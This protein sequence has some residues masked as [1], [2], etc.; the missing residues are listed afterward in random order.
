MKK[1]AEEKRRAQEREAELDKKRKKI[2]DEIMERYMRQNQ[3]SMMGKMMSGQ[4]LYGQGGIGSPVGNMMAY[5]AGMPDMKQMYAMGSRQGQQA[6]MFNHMLTQQTGSM[7]GIGQKYGSLNQVV[8]HRP[9]YQYNHGSLDNDKGAMSH[10]HSQAVY[11]DLG[12]LGKGDGSNWTPG[13]P[14]QIKLV[15]RRRLRMIEAHKNEYA[16]DEIYGKKCVKMSEF[17]ELC[18]GQ[19]YVDLK[20]YEREGMGDRK[21]MKRQFEHRLNALNESAE[22]GIVNEGVRYFV[23]RQFVYDQSGELKQCFDVDGGFD[24]CLGQMDDDESKMWLMIGEDELTVFE[25]ED[26][27]NWDEVEAISKRKKESV[28]TQKCNFVYFGSIETKICIQETQNKGHNLL[29]Y[30]VIVQY[31]AAS[32]FD[33][34]L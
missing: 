28:I 9:N 13:Q 3:N 7:G 8:H 10:E 19:N 18:V 30:R 15:G 22:H 11:G 5:G 2:E 14:L 12:P 31:L 1:R 34:F 16:V 25:F 24:V 4:S 33:E 27:E 6:G 29:L 20:Q 26:D 32:Q 17:S 21:L 23:Q